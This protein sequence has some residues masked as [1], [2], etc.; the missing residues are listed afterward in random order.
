MGTTG[1]VQE[2]KAVYGLTF[3]QPESQ[4]LALHTTRARTPVVQ[5][6]RRGGP[7]RD[8]EAAT[9]HTHAGGVTRRLAGTVVQLHIIPLG[10]A[11]SI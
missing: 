6:A 11:G 9:R 8:G 5:S 7:I 3:P 1:G 4:R 10:T 2:Y